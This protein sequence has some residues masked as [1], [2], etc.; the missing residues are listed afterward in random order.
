MLGAYD[1]DQHAPESGNC[2]IDQV[3]YREAR[4]FEIN[5]DHRSNFKIDEQEEDVSE[6]RLTLG[7]HSD[8]SCNRGPDGRSADCEQGEIMNAS[9]KSAPSVSTVSFM[10]RC[11]LLVAVPS[12]RI[13]S[14]IG[15]LLVRDAAPARSML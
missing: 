9:T 13:V 8:E 15:P 6:A 4:G 2:N 7:D 10:P 11:R 1:F 14:N 3:S 12:R 5:A